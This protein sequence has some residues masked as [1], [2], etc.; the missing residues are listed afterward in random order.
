MQW[1]ILPYRRYFE[2]G[3]R[4]RRK[5]F[6]MF[7][8]FVFLV[9]IVISALFGVGVAEQVDGFAS[10]TRRLTPTGNAIQGLFSLATI[11]PSLAVAARRLHDTGRSA[12]WLL[13]LFFVF[14]G[15]IVLLVF[16]CL[17]G[18]KGPN[19]FGPDPKDPTGAEVF[20]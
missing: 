20:A 11:I 19:R 13:L 12:W 1:M 7:T 17:D 2:F 6:W 14:V 4:S 15:W 18:D 9:G 16:Y 10:Y 8:L 3:G 5:E